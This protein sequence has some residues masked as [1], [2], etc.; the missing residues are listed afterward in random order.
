MLYL[1]DISLE[2]FSNTNCAAYYFFVCYQ[3]NNNIYNYTFVN[4][5]KTWSDAQLYCKSAYHDLAVIENEIYMT[6]AVCQ[7]DFPVWTGLY[8]DGKVTLTQSQ[9]VMFL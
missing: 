7:Q 6:K 2:R 9:P 8:R 4:Q 5:A 1:S 3:L